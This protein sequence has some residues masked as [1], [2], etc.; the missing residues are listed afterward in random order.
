MMPDTGHR[1]AATQFVRYGIAGG[2][3][4]AT[5]LVVLWGLHELF[6]VEEVLASAVGF[7]AAIPVNYALQHR[8]V[9]SSQRR[10]VT[11]APRYLATT[12]AGLGLNTILFALATLVLA[13]PYL[14]AQVIVTVL[15]FLFNFLVNRH[16]TFSNP[17]GETQT[18]EGTI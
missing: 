10:H 15:V 2:C 7:L 14:L 9:F 1:K 18:G 6:G 17:A 13:I 3:A 12:L 8:Y 11:A 4:L 16:F 5:H